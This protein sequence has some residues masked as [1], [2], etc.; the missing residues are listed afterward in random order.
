VEVHT[1][2]AGHHANGMD[3]QV[4]HMRWVLDFFARHA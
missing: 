4:Q 2:G 1:Y 3:E